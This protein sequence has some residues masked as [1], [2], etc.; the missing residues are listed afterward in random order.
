MSGKSG[1]RGL[2]FVAIPNIIDQARP[3]LDD[4]RDTAW[5]GNLLDL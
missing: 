4:N 3:R 5:T 2:G 1:G